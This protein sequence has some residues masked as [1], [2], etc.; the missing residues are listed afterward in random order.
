MKQVKIKATNITPKQ[1]S[2]LLLELNLMVKA[3]KP[4][5]NLTLET[6][7][8]QKVIAWGTRKGKD[9]E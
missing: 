3:W 6:K 9:S 5:A 4:F 8:L 7:G 1:W 2:T